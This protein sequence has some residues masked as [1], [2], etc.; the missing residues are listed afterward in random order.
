MQYEIIDCP[1]CSKGKIKILTAPSYRK[2]LK[3]GF[4]DISEQM[5]VLDDCSVCGK[6]IKEITK[7]LKK[8]SFSKEANKNIIRRLKESGFDNFVEKF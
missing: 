1:F 2:Y 5:E 3:G 7:N 4:K 8:V 6:T